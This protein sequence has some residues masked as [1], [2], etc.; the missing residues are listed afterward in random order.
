MRAYLSRAILVEA[1]LLLLLTSTGCGKNNKSDL[2][3]QQTP[4]VAGPGPGMPGKPS[5]LRGIMTKM[6]KG[7]QSLH[8]SLGRELK[9]DPP[10]WESI[11]PQA[12]EYAQMAGSLGQLDPPKGSKDS[13]AKLTA[14]F[15]ESATALE[16]AAD[17][18]DK[19]AALDAH[20]QLSESC[21]TCHRE[22]RAGPGRPPG[23]P[24]Q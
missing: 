3:D 20:L 8:E 6:A 11:Q 16:R 13:W 9:A 23:P 2:Q 1:L 14:S 18:K 24:P 7:P 22:H 5:P 15:R 21:K 19:K 10:P 12:R 4:P 17:A